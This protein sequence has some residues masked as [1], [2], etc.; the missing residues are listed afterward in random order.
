MLS[1]FL[2]SSVGG[3][4]SSENSDIFAETINPTNLSIEY[5]L[6]GYDPD[7]CAASHPSFDR[8]G[9]PYLIVD[10]PF[11]DAEP[12]QGKV[13]GRLHNLMYLRE[14]GWHFVDLRRILRT[15]FKAEGEIVTYSYQFEF[16]SDSDE[17]F[18]LVQY[19]KANGLYALVLLLS[20]DHGEHFVIN[21]LE[22]NYEKAFDRIDTEHFAGHNVIQWPI[23]VAASRRGNEPKIPSN[24][25][26]DHPGTLFYYI[27]NKKSGKVNTVRKG[28]LSNSSSRNP[29][30][31]IY[32]TTQIVSTK[33]KI[34][35]VWHDT[36]VGARRGENR[37]YI[38]TYDKSKDSWSLPTYIGPSADDHGYPTVV[39]DSKNYIHVLCGAHG[40][41][42]YYTHSLRPD[43]S[44][45]FL[46]LEAVPGAK[47]ATHLSLISDS[48]DRLHLFFRDNF[49]NH[50]FKSA[51]LSYITRN[52]SWGK[53]RRLTNC[54]VRGYC[55][56]L[57][58]VS[59]DK[60]GRLFL[61]Y[62][63]FTLEPWSEDRMQ[64]WY[65]PVLAYSKDGGNKWMLVPNNFLTSIRNDAAD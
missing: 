58:H 25:F 21:C 56:M 1:M 39:L 48:K 53:I 60:N 15:Y 65:Y 20:S 41:Q 24:K 46:P 54:P 19:R 34:H 10:Y 29:I 22:E 8:S 37:T 36:Q 32:V 44:L 33:D 28:V 45:A 43:D 31:S 13:R 35:I 12:Q 4:N 62:G 6:W 52:D 9:R 42:V 18:L 23:L 11:T 64:N 55:R 63:Y 17:M 3:A 26:K 50:L 5:K 14:D 16:I 47:R 51:G 30:G 61:N 27:I 40:S 49:R 38:R 2:M 59:M 57:N 7:Y